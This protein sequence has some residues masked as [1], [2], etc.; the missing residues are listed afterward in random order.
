PRD[1]RS[2]QQ[3]AQVVALIPRPGEANRNPATVAALQRAQG[4]STFASVR[5]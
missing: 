2:G 3:S 4:E 5:I 1:E